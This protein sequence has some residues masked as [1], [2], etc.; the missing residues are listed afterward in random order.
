MLRTGDF[1]VVNSVTSCILDH[2]NCP[3]MPVNFY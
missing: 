2:V 1:V 3:A